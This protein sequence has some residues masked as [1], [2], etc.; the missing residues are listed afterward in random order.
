[1]QSYIRM[2]SGI[3]LFPIQPINWK[4]Y[5]WKVNRK[6]RAVVR[7]KHGKIQLSMIDIRRSP[8]LMGEVDIV[9]TVLLVPGVSTVGEAAT[10]FNVRGG[11]IDQNLVMQDGQM[12]FNSAHLL[13]FF[14]I[15]NPDVVRN[16]TLYKGTYSRAVWRKG[17][18]CSGC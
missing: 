7:L 16:L 5:S 17:F 10:G 15:F 6:A 12:I 18:F 4:K 1:M 14:S 11:N 13:G 8:S 2:E 9:N 3:F